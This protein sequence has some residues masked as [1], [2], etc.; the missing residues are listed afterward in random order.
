MALV[1]VTRIQRIARQIKLAERARLKYIKC[2]NKGNKNCDR[3]LDRIDKREAKKIKLQTELSQKKGFF[4]EAEVQAT[5]IHAFRQV[6]PGPMST[7]DFATISN[8]I[9]DVEIDLMPVEPES[10]T[11]TYVVSGVAFVG[12]AT[13]GYFAWRRATGRS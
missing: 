5:G 2:I 13:L 7:S 12:F 1:P 6:P 3:F 11:M 4:T 10:N 8:S 9:S